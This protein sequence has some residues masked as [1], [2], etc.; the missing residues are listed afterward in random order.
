MR[1]SLQGVRGRVTRL[2]SQIRNGCRACRE[3]EAKIRYRWQDTRADSSRRVNDELTTLPQ[4]QTCAVCGRTY[5]L[6]YTIISWLPD[7]A[8]G[9]PPSI[10]DQLIP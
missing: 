10:G 5:A 1:G 4:V 7:D 2:A 8:V 6:Q 3:D 9:G